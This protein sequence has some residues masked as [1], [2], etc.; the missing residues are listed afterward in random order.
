MSKPRPGCAHDAPASVPVPRAA[1]KEARYG[2]ARFP[3]V[4]YPELMEVRTPWQGGDGRAANE[5]E[6]K[7]AA[8]LDRKKVVHT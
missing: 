1:G 8:K 3:D 2:P 4:P 6:R 7:P 5:P